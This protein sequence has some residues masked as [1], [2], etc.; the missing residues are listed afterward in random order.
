M[1]LTK[2]TDNSLRVLIFLSLEPERKVNI[3]EIA[4]KCEVPRNHLIKVVHAMANRG[5]LETTRGKGG[6]VRLG[7]DPAEITVG[8]VVRVMEGNLNIVECY[9]PRCPIVP[10]CRLRGLLNGARDEFLRALD[11]HTIAELVENKSA[12][13]GLIGISDS[14]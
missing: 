3:T 7:R 14:H 5:L 13:K 8:E 9:E 1:H 11:K 12:M 10:M 4:E 6:G 2:F